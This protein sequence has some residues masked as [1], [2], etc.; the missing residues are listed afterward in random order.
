M[1]KLVVEL[2]HLTPDAVTLVGNKAAAQAELLQAGF[3]V[4]KGVCVTTE[5]FALAI[6]DRGNA[7]TAALGHADVAKAAHDCANLLSDLKV[8]GTVMDALATVWPEL[9]SGRDLV[10]V[11][12]SGTAED[13]ADASFAGQ[14]ATILGVQGRDAIEKAIITCWSS[15]YAAGAIAERRKYALNN[16]AMAVLIQPV[17]AAECA[18]VAFSVDPVAHDPDRIII[19]AAW[20]LGVGVMDGTVASDTYQVRRA[21]FQVQAQVTEKPEQI[22]VDVT[23]KRQPIPVPDDQQ[24]AACLPDKWAQ[25]I[26]QYAVAAEQ[27]FGSPQDVEW[28]IMDQQ[29]WILQSRPITALPP[30]VAQVPPFPVAWT[31]RADRHNLWM[32]NNDS[33]TDEGPVPPLEQDHVHIKESIREETCKFMGADRNLDVRYFNGRAYSRRLPLDQTDGDRRIRRQAM[34]DLK[35]RLKMEGWNA[36]DYWGP[37][38]EQA[39]RRLRNFD[40]HH[41]DALALADNLE[42]AIAV[43]RRHS[44]LHP[45]LWFRPLPSYQTAFERVT[46]LSGEEAIIAAHQLL[47]GSETPFTKLVDSLYEL[48]QCV[49]DDDL[50]QRVIEKQAAFERLPETFRRK[51]RDFIA[52]YG[53]RTGDGWGSETTIM[54][55]TW[56]EDPAHV[57]RMIAAFRGPTVESPATIR[58]QAQAK[59]DAQ[60]EA[61]IV[62]CDDPT[63]VAELRHE[64]DYA[65]H[66]YTVLELH[67]HFIDQLANGQ[68]RHAVMAAARWLVEHNILAQP[69]NI[70]WLTF[71][72]ILTALREG[73]NFAAQ[74][75]ARQSEFAAWETY[76]APP[77]L[78]IPSADLPERLPYGDDV[79]TLVAERPGVLR[80]M[81]ASP[82]QY[83]GMCRV[84]IDYNT[85]LTDIT[86]GT[87]LVAP[88]VGPRWTPI[89]PLLGAMVLDSGSI[90][91]HAAATAREY[92]IPAVTNTRTATQILRDGLTVLVDGGAGVVNVL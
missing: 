90:G 45:M 65:K 82:G 28:A 57:L 32:L 73:E 6:S 66:V 2:E 31:D 29:V 60:L 50:L 68:L 91:Q 39:T 1:R 9:L 78:G 64:L 44:M 69:D 23:G 12:S 59:R 92:G 10:A 15:F 56:R 8:P 47:D 43:R 88:N 25:R 13:L 21:G 89:I 83:R 17:I 63:A 14:Y 46:G 77:L 27:H 75:T 33:G 58:Q 71:T 48:A 22:G 34:A 3:P 80:G 87:I 54:T 74:I 76:T 84:V 49:P 55:P 24:R 81:G 7:I 37:E 38:I 18:G 79:T 4:P 85:D 86:P 53:E 30:D 5:A 35:Q 20:G 40:V 72:E 62:S 26:A 42:D 36:W 16:A 11:R 67:N 19:N 41:A 61:W 52:A 51:Y 70:F